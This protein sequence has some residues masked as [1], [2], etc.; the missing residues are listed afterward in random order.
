MALAE[1]DGLHA[2]NSYGEIPLDNDDPTKPREAYFKH[3]DYIIDLA[4]K[5][6]LAIGFLPTWGDKLWKSTWGK[7]PEIFTPDNAKNY[8]K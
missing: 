5:Y 1:F 6:G 7:G 2:P 4:N 8:S 3:V